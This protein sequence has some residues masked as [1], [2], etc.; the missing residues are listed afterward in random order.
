MVTRHGGV[1]RVDE[2]HVARATS[3]EVFL[4]LL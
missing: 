4:I 3:N 1:R 2:R